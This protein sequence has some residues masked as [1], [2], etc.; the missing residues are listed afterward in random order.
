MSLSVK[1]TNSFFRRATKS[2][3][4]R[5]RSEIVLSERQ[6]KIFDMYY[7]RR[8]DLGFIADTLCMSYPAAKSELSSIR[9]KLIPLL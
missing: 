2:E 3:I 9:E 8:K 6:E 7:I 1:K 4:E 5:V